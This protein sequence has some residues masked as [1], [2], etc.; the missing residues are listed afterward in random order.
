[1]KL[2]ALIL[3]LIAPTWAVQASAQTATYSCNEERVP[4]KLNFDLENETVERKGNI[5]PFIFDNFTV[6]WIEKK[7]DKSTGL[8]VYEQTT[9]MLNYH[10]FHYDSGGVYGSS[11]TS[12]ALNTG[13]KI[14][15]RL[16][17]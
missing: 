9:E 5:F 15:C 17:Q 7:H 4:F 8:Y 6:S 13:P 12:V 16:L 10:Q 2:V 3:I 1:M 11:G 14:K